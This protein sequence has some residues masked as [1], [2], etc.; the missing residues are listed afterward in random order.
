MAMRVSEIGEFGLIELLSR[1]LG[2]E[3]PPAKGRPPRKG[4]LVDL[5]DDAVV[6]EPRAGAPVWTT[7]T[8]VEGVHFLPAATPWRNVGWKALA[9]NVSD[10]AAMGATPDL[11]LVTLSLPPEF[12]VED[13]V[14][15][16]RGIAE[17]CR[18]YGVTVGGGDIVRS[19]VFAVTVALSGTAAISAGGDALVLRRDAAGPGD[20]VAVTGTLG[21]SAAGIRLLQA[22]ADRADP[23]NESLIEAHERPR[24]RLEAGLRAVASGLRCG[25]DV[26]DGLLQDAGHVA[27]ASGVRIRID[28]ASVPLS[29]Q[30]RAAFPADAAELALTGGEDYQL[31]L[32]GP[33]E[34]IGRLVVEGLDLTIVG[35]VEAGAPGVV[36][37]DAGGAERAY[38][39][40]GWDHF[41]S[42]S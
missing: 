15:L 34:I 4:L 36:A 22:G 23:A 41:R 26:S 13:A 16:Y 3:Y 24:P 28:I 19:P 40:G 10:I 7:D 8:L 30:L 14:D 20:A 25:I 21:D 5:G 2:I 37:V 38:A 1:E 35:R 42:A 9:V 39:D 17:C 31:L 18:A 33:R 11:A 29:P 27:R 6:T 32:C 12:C